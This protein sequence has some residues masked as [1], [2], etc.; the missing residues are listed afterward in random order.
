MDIV[1]TYVN[2]ADPEWQRSYAEYTH[3]PLITKRY[4]DWGTLKYLLRA[5]QKNLPFIGNVFLWS[6]ADP[7][8]QNGHRRNSRS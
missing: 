1:I 8:C 3:K 2:G 7:R 6:Q 5:I 4:R